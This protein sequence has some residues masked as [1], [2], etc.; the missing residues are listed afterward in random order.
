VSATALLRA[1]R[2]W[3]RDMLCYAE[4]PPD[5]FALLAAH[6]ASGAD[7]VVEGAV[8]LSHAELHR[9]AAALSG[10]LATRGLRP[11]DRVALVL[12]NRWAFAVIFLA[13]L[14]SGLIAVPV[15]PRASAPEL[16]HLLADSGTRL[17]L[18]D[19]ASA[20]LLSPEAPE[21]WDVDAPGF[22]E[23]LAAAP[24]PPHAPWEEDTAVLLYTSGTTGRPKGAMLT[25]LG[26]VHSALHFTQAFSLGPQDRSLM[27]VPASHVT[28]LVANLL[29]ILGAGG[30]LLVLPRF[31]V[32]A[33]LHLARTERM[34]HT[35]VVPAMYELLL[36]RADL[37]SAGL[38]AW[39]IGAYGGAPMAPAT[40]E[41]LALALPHLRLAN[42]YGATETTSPATLMPPGEMGR[43]ASVGRPV[44]CGSIRVVNEAGRDRPPGE[45]GEI[46]IAGPMVVPGYWRNEEAT[47][48][49]FEGPWWRSGDI[50]ALDAEGYLS[51]L[52]R[53]KDVINRGGY[54]VFSA[55]V[56]AVL[57]RHEAVAEAAV[58]PRP[59]PVLGE[60]VVAVVHPREG[61][62]VDEAALRAHCVAH[63]ADYKVPESVVA[64]P[65]P[66]PR[67]ANG[68]I[69]KRD[70][71]GLVPL[72]SHQE[73]ER[74]P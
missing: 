10:A 1:E 20:A 51:V 19:R 46:W 21:A 2:H 16:A 52:D 26:L 69:V 55:E 45:P 44:P 59:C 67:N 65:E 39:R 8:R 6:A 60:R 70:L 64:S 66:L 4:R 32:G 57:L 33:F 12:G 5:A 61:W 38:G 63:L 49:A 11:G 35:L 15:N 31:E 58:L 17:V 71:R 53:L 14:R 18:H 37:A 34:T 22:A 25:H 36:R 50:G 74:A 3:G 27:A 73:R 41:R 48:R 42:A 43:G 68:K 29:T 40:I 54:K 7:A 72:A 24:V 62:A 23:A 56:E 13:L 30:A 28:G 47:A 9:R